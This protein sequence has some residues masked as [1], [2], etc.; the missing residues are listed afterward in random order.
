LLYDTDISN[1]VRG[2]YDYEAQ[3]DDE[4]GVREG[5]IIQLTPGPNGGQNYAD[6]WWEGKYFVSAWGYLAPD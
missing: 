6:G 3:G 4:L 2:V 1:L 5:E